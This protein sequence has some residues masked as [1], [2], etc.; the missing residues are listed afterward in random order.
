MPSGVREK[1]RKEYDDN[2]RKLE[3]KHTEVFDKPHVKL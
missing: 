1:R 2:D 3:I